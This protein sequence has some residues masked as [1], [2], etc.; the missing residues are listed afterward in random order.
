MHMS[1]S[2]QSIDKVFINPVKCIYVT[3]ERKYQ[4]FLTVHVV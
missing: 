4:H 2:V 3:S 1:D